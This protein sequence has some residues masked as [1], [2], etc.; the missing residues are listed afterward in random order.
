MT[1]ETKNKKAAKP[2]VDWELVERQYRTGQFT[3]RELARSHG[4]S[5]TAIAKKAKQFGWVKDLSEKIQQAAKSE[6]ARRE[7]ATVVSTETKLSEAATVQVFA[8]KVADVDMGNRADLR[9]VLEVQ[10]TLAQELAALSNPAFFEQLEK[11]GEIMDETYTTESG[12]EVKDKV[13]ETYRY[14]ISLAGRVKMAKDLAGAYGV[15]VPLQRKIYGLDVEK[16]NSSELEQLLDE[17]RREL[18]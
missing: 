15:Y 2:P 17:V 5:H 12:R 11:L 9:A 18:A 8:E 6:V 1:E 7:V 3:D 14:I 4:C 16:K 13:N 10:R